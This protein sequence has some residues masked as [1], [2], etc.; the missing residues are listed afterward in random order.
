[1]GLGSTQPLTEKSTRNLPVGVNGGRRVK[2]TSPPSVSRLS[3]ICGSL[4]VPQP[5]RPPQ[6]VIG[7]ASPFFTLLG[8]PTDVRLLYCLSAYILYNNHWTLNG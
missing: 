6:R 8:L 1:M 5:Y 7:I 3:R 4:D 2:L